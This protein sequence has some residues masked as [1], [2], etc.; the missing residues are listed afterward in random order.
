[1]SHDLVG[2]SSVNWIMKAFAFEVY[3]WKANLGSFV[4]NIVFE[5]QPYKKGDILQRMI[6]VW[7]FPFFWDISP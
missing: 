6:N 1:M 5:N 2:F 3:F 7:I 4:H